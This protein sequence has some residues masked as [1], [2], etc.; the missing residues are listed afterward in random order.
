MHRSED[1][2]CGAEA[3]KAIAASA[4]GAGLTRTGHW[5]C[6]A[7]L[8]AAL[9]LWTA[10]QRS[11]SE[12]PTAPTAPPV[13]VTLTRAQAEQ[14]QP[15][16]QKLLGDLYASGR[17]VT[18]D[19]KQAF[20]WYTKA[21]EQG[22]AAAQNSLGELCEAGQGAEP[23]FETAAEWYR[24]AA[25]AGNA[26]AQYNLAVLYAFGRGVKLNEAEAVKWYQQAAEQGH[27]LAQFNIGQRYQL[28][29]GVP[30][31]LVEAYKWLSLA[32]KEVPDSAKISDEVKEKLSRQQLAEA[33]QRLAAFQPREKGANDKRP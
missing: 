25:E 8:L 12:T 31:D 30:Q 15:D 19:F 20:A 7:L 22:N 18:Q 3:G 4:R 9:A 10:C 27:A 2:S 21:A 13:D 1:E 5:G 24:K 11:P 6:G 26:S 29:K 32:A 14:G 33:R 28:G 16:A 23:S 17:G